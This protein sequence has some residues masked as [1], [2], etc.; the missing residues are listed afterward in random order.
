[1]TSLR[2]LIAL[3]NGIQSN[4]MPRCLIESARNRKSTRT[5]VR[6]WVRRFHHR[7]IPS[8]NRSPPILR[9]ERG[10]R[11]R[12]RRL[13]VTAIACERVLWG[14]GR[15]DRLWPIT[16]GWD[17]SNLTPAAGSNLGYYELRSAIRCPI[18]NN[19]VNNA[20]AAVPR[21]VLR[22]SDNGRSLLARIVVD[23]PLLGAPVA[24]TGQDLSFAPCSPGGPIFRRSHRAARLPIVSRFAHY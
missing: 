2:L 5:R 7:I 6:M 12:R 15:Y 13:D 10:F 18:L 24:L 22:G 11:P 1:M 3:T 23:S 16:L 19:E 17:R 21:S 14:T 20:A 4:P 9:P 8:T